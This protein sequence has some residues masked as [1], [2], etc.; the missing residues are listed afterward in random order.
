MSSNTTVLDTSTP[1]PTGGH[2]E[3]QAG[4]NNSNT[5]TDS[6]PGN[7]PPPPSQHRSRGPAHSTVG[8]HRGGRRRRPQVFTL[9]DGRRVLVAL[10]EDAAA[11]R[12]KYAS[13]RADTNPAG[14][15]ADDGDA[16]NNDDDDD[17]N[18]YQVEVVV[19]G[20]PEHRQY[21]E[22][23][24]DHQQARRAA[25][26]ARYGAGFFDEWD[27]T[28]AELDRVSTELAQ[29]ADHAATLGHNFSKFGYS[30]TLRTFGGS[31]HGGGGGSHQASRV[32][33]HV[34]SRT[35]SDVGID[36]DDEEGDDDDDA[37]GNSSA[38]DSIHN[39]GGGGGSGGVVPAWHNP[40]NGTG[41]PLFKRPMV[42]QYFHRGLL[43]RA[44]EETSVQSF[45]LFFD[46]LYVGII[47]VNGDHAAEAANGF[48]LLRFLVT[49]CLS[50]KIWSD[51][52]QLLSWFETNDVLQRVEVLF[53]FACLVGVTVNSVQTFGGWGGAPGGEGE[54]AGDAGGAAPDENDT[55]PALAAFYVTARLFMALY[56]AVTGLLAPLVRGTLFCQAAVITVGAALW[57]ASIHL[58]LPARLACVFVALVFDLFVAGSLVV[59]L[60]RY[61]QARAA[62]GSRTARALIARLFDFF[63][64]MNIEHKV[65]RTNAF[66]TLVLGYSVVGVL[67]QNNGGYGLNAFFGKAVLGLVQAFLFNW[68]Y[69]D[70]DGANI[71]VH[72]IRRRAETA[73]V[74]QYAHLLFTLAFVLSSAALTRLVVA[75][76]CRDAP[77]SALATA[78]QERAAPTVALGLRLYYSTGLGVALAT[79][80]LIAAC[81]RHKLPPTARLSKPVRL[82]NR[83]AVAAVLCALPAAQERL[84]SLQLV[85]VATGLLVWVVVVEVVGLSCR[86]DTFVQFRRAA[87]GS[88][89]GADGSCQY[90]ARC[91]RKRLERAL[92]NNNSGGETG[93]DEEQPGVDVNILSRGEKHGAIY[94]E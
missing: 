3:S 66:V 35:A 9:P 21:L 10:P 79:T 83:L 82:A 80:A 13:L 40:R 24:R 48:E 63:P 74:W 73:Y 45:E 54:G 5:S 90:T 28:T 11:L 29:L 47:A 33:S 19:H 64:A 89:A 42:K 81:H 71:H 34:S 91:S 20:S 36:D 12:A 56:C 46:L 67:Y 50:W 70:I 77:L 51:V 31:E 94:M 68:L 32:A 14:D 76:D 25:L 27:R 26:E 8:R 44:S 78:D 16:N 18:N 23:S 72:A 39:G 61:A 17:N 4:N 59:G 92:Q 41:M 37:G 22:A 38:E 87:G 43:W 93:Q 57:I 52:T 84:T 2:T 55:Y 49:F 88:S 75:T 86:G 53:L 58:P 65:E 1:A 85:A 69:F 30:A 6:P 15:R 7:R 60:F 62:T